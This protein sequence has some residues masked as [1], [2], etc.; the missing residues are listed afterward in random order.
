MSV[1][2]YK[3]TLFN[4]GL[5]DME[6]SSINEVF[7]STSAYDALCKAEKLLQKYKTRELR[8]SY[9]TKQFLEALAISADADIHIK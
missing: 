9:R 6:R 4:N 3:V 5:N 8:V 1:D 2:R 7:S